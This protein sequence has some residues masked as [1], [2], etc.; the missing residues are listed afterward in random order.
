M[1][2]VVETKRLRFFFL[3]ESWSEI[4][5]MTEWEDAKKTR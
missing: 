4:E 3:R 1:K 2:E 5:E